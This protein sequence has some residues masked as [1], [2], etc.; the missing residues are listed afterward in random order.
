MMEYLGFTLLL[1][2]A[3]V[4]NTL[5]GLAQHRY[6]VRTVRRLAGEHNKAGCVLVSGR[7]RGRLRGAVAILVLRS[8]DDVIEG[9]AVMEGASIFARF[10]DRPD[11]LGLSAIRPLPRCSPRLAA[12]VAQARTRVPGRA[13]TSGVPAPAPTRRRLGWG[14]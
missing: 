11:W 7:A 2:A 1:I 3:L 6:Y 13:A 14:R 8:A 4:L 12:A 5:S 10:K 9:A